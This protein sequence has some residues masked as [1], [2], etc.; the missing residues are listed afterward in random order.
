ML[1]RFSR[2]VLFAFFISFL[3]AGIFSIIVTI[4][5]NDYISDY[6]LQDEKILIKG[7]ETKILDKNGN[8]LAEFKKDNKKPTEYE[9]IPIEVIEA[10][11]STEDQDFFEHSGINPKAILR[12]IIYDIKA[13]AFVQGGS[14]VTQQLIK[15]IYL[16]PGKTLD[17]KID[18]AVYAVLLEEKMPKKDIM[19]YYLNHIFYGNRANG[20][21]NAIRT[22]Y[23]QTLEEF[24]KNDESVRAERAALLVGIVNAPSAYDPYLHTDLATER[25]NTV[26]KKMYVEGYIKK[27]VFETAIS[28]PLSVLEKPITVGDD[29]KIHYPEYVSYIL[30]E[31]KEVMGYESIEE[32]MYSGMQI[33]TSFDPEVYK[34]IRKNMSR[35]E[36]YPT[37]AKDGKQVQ[38]SVV[39]IN[40]QNG[41][42]YAMSGA[43]E[44][45]KEFLVLN[46]A[47]QSKRQPGSSIKPLIS[48]GPALES[49]KFTPSSILPCSASFGTY[50]LKASCSGSRSMADSLKYSSNVPAV[51][52]LKQVGIKNATAFINKLGIV[53]DKDDVYLPIALGGLTYGVTPLQLTDA[54]QAFANKGMRVKAH[55]IKRITNPINEVIYEPE[56]PKQVIKEKTADDMTRM[57]KGAVSGGTGRSA[58]VSGEQI[59]GKTGTNELPGSG[60]NKDI[61]FVGYNEILVGTVWMGFDQTDKT[62]FIKSG[63]TSYLAAKM[64]S[65]IVSQALK[66]IP[67]NK[68]TEEKSLNNFSFNIKQNLTGDR[69][70]LEWQSKSNIKYEIYRNNINI[71]STEKN[72]FSEALSKSGKYTYKIVG[73]NIKTGKKEFE[74]ENIP[75]ELVYKEAVE[76]EKPVEPKPKEPEKV[77]E[78][79]PTPVPVPAPTPT[80]TPA[81]APEPKPEPEPAPDVKVDE[82]T[83]TNTD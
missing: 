40:P 7:V 57:L 58:Q 53:L 49:G 82:A 78:P 69:V 44:E 50:A 47:F 14:T 67:K 19:A 3:I 64:Y 35:N 17:R 26:L 48:Y 21:E 13:G 8:K 36:L 71:G 10:V 15:W 77:P 29:E 34:I 16:D 51:W 59:A 62:H 37:N 54:F 73:Y 18:E 61:W 32:V 9:N 76:E 70:V 83:E 5:V 30:S 68:I 27:E 65:E 1:K 12:A 4:F 20:I 25:R 22:Y 11:V 42:I 23:G 81:P 43:R 2:N 52:T 24:N 56:K 74:S 46:R 39:L 41:E 80:P 45:T 55:T 63:Q 75:F 6:E 28:K 60:G 72:T 38:S 31:A 66:I 79:A 33:Y